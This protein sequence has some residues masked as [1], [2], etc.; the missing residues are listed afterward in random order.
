ML[1]GKYPQLV[2]QADVDHDKTHRWLKAPGLKA[3]TEDLSSLPKIKAFQHAGTTTTSSRSLTWT[4]NADHLVSGC[5]ELAKTEYIHRQ[6]KTTAHMHCKICKEFGIGVKE[7]WYE[8]EP[9]AVTEKDS[10][11]ILWDMSIH[12]DRTIAAKMPDI[13][14][15]NKKDK[16]CLLIDMTMPLDT[17][18]SVKTT[19]K[20]KK[21]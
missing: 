18:T 16:T 5:P 13:V 10:V 4:Q 19:E 12:T 17:N 2:K 8:H 7:R 6:H 1:P 9:K 21:K 3:E 11:T 15:K 14:L 20:L